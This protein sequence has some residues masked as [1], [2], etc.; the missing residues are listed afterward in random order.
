[1]VLGYTLDN[2][3]L[4]DEDGRRRLNRH[5]GPDL[6]GTF[7]GTRPGYRADWTTEIARRSFGGDFEF[8]RHIANVRAYVP[9]SPAQELRGRLIV[10][11]S[12]GTLPPQRWF[13]LGGIGSVHGYGFKE[14]AG[15]RMVLGNIEYLVGSQRDFYAIGFFDIGRVSRPLAGSAAWMKGIGAGLG[16]S[17]LRFDFGWRASDIPKSFQMLVRF[18]P[19]F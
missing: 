13:A 9:L 6:F 10:G 14:S 3:A 18:G 17:D 1:V 7:G 4:E 5:L 2:R 8:T 15:E 16:F 19:T 12:S 11:T